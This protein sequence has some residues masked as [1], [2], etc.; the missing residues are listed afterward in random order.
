MH[1]ESRGAGNHDMRPYTSDRR[2]H[3][4]AH[5]DKK[6]STVITNPDDPKF[7]LEAYLTKVSKENP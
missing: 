2:N 4:D 1:H 3:H 6:L 7:D 5:T